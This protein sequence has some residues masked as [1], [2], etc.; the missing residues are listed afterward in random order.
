MLKD[1]SIESA[2]VF[3]KTKHGANKVTAVLEAADIKSAAIHGNKSQNARQL[4]LAGLKSK[5]IRVLVATDIAA[6]GIDVD[7]LSHV[8]IFDIPTEPETYVHRI[9]RTGR[10]GASGVAIVF[11]DHDEKKYLND[12]VKLIK[13]EIPLM[14]DHPYPLIHT[15][16][17]RDA[18]EARPQ[19][20]SFG[21]SQK[22]FTPSKTFGTTRRDE[23]WPHTSAKSF[24]Q[25]DSA[26]KKSYITK[27]DSRPETTFEQREAKRIQR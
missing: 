25:T 24:G 11:C 26:P 5:K 15:S 10:A 20:R 18:L 14:G 16:S 21:R 4:A 23:A 1:P 27:K 13:Q 9:G 8:F 12:I 22:E 19:G 2:I 17:G 7:Q 6:R 3:T